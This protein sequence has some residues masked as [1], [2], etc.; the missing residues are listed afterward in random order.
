M[1]P[2]CASNVRMIV[3]KRDLIKVIKNVRKISVYS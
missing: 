1:S 2:C 3:R